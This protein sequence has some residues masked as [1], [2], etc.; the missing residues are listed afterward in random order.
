MRRIAFA[1]ILGLTVFAGCK[2][3]FDDSKNSVISGDIIPVAS[4]TLDLHENT[5]E[6]GESFTLNATILPET[7]TYKSVSWET[8]QPGIVSVSSSG[9]VKGLAK[10][11]CTITAKAGEYSDECL[12]HVN[13]ARPNG[14]V[15][16]G[17]SVYW[18]NRNIGASKESD[19]GEFYAWGEKE[20]KSQYLQGNY[21]NWSGSAYYYRVFDNFH[22]Y[23]TATYQL[24]QNW[25]MPTKAEV[26]EL[27]SKCN[28]RES[29]VNGNTCYI[30]TSKT[31]SDISITLPKCGVSNSES[32]YYWC[33]TFGSRSPDAMLLTKISSTPKLQ[34]SSYDGWCGLPIRPVADK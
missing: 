22:T 26:E 1:L 29:T 7:A 12:V 14:A 27:I 11:D 6:V 21:T 34:T 24:G 16:L 30:V 18:R 4:I 10:G 32:T 17:C 28:V 9:E 5:I 13:K 20:Y 31:N 33:S 15:D 23:D 3:K 2:K 8:S 25:R 19:A